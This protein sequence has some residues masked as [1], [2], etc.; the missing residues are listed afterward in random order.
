MADAAPLLEFVWLHE[1]PPSTPPDWIW[2]GYIAKGRGTLLT[3]FA[4]VG[5]STLLSHLLLQMSGEGGELITA[6]KPQR[7]LVVSEEHEEEWRER[8]DRMGLGDHVRLT[9]ARRGFKTD[10]KQWGQMTCEI[11][12]EC[13]K[14]D[15]GL[16]VYDTF[17]R[18]CPAKDENSSMEIAA[19]QAPLDVLK[20]AGLAVLI[21]HHDRKGQGGTAGEKGRGSGDFQAF[22]DIVMEFGFYK[23]DQQCEDRKRMLRARGRPPGVPPEIV[24]EL[25]DDGNTYEVLGTGAA[26]SSEGLQDAIE[27]ALIAAGRRGLSKA[28][29]AHSLAFAP[30]ASKLYGVLA[31]GAED[32]RWGKTGSG[33]RGSPHRYFVKQA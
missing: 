3:G 30:S 7:V 33:G 32:G 4:K 13:R 22:A 17:A 15:I 18:V 9:S 25:S 5:K 23:K 29:I 26:L 14:S 12:D 27:G 11:L 8:R 1:L 19:A 16:V 31:K 2:E 10:F 28:D 24:L 21:L 6:V 20:N